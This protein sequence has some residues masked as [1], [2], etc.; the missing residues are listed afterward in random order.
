M[1]LEVRRLRVSIDLSLRS[2]RGIRGIVHIINR[3]LYKQFENKT[4]S[5][6]NPDLQC[7]LKAIDQY[8][9]REGQGI[10]NIPQLYLTRESRP[11]SVSILASIR[12]VPS[13][14]LLLPLFVDDRREGSSSVRPL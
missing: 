14:S 12:R 4:N 8:D 11:A 9:T 6:K 10:Q 1:Y 5:T 3:S 13:S 2:L 7:L